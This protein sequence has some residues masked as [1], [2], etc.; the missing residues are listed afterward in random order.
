MKKLT[1]LM[2]S[3]ILA[4]VIN[5]SQA[6]E[7]WIRPDGT[8][9]TGDGSAA[10]PYV[11]TNAASFDALMLTI[12]TN[13]IIH[14]M[15]G[16]F[17]TDGSICSAGWPSLKSGQKLVGAGIDVTTIKLSDGVP[18][19]SRSVISSCP[20]SD[21][22]VA[23]LT[24]D[25]NSPGTGTYFGVSL[26][27]TRCAVRRVKVIRASHQVGISS[28]AY[29]IVILGTPTA[30][31]DGNV[32][33]DCEVSQFIGSGLISGI[34][35]SAYDDHYVSGVIRNN[36]V[37][38]PPPANG[39]AINHCNSR[40]LLIHGNYVDGAATG[41]YGDC[42]SYTNVTISHNLFRN[43]HVAGVNIINS[44]TNDSI[45]VLY[46]RVEL[47]NAFGPGAAGVHFVAPAG[48]RY[49]NISVIGNSMRREP[50]MSPGASLQ[51]ITLIGVDGAIVQNN[52]AEASMVSLNSGNT[53]VHGFSNRDFSGNLLPYM[54]DNP[55]TIRKIADQSITSDDTL[56]DD[57][58]LKFTMAANTKYTIRLKVFFTTG[59]TPDFKYRVAGPSATLVRRQISR[60][61]G[62]L[63]PTTP[64]IADTYPAAD[65]PLDGTGAD[66]FIE[67]EI[68]VHNGGTAGDF[69]FRWSQNASSAT[70]TKVL[71]GS[72]IEYMPF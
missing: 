12:P 2:V 36:R 29:G 25:C 15:A 70:P 21:I 1:L 16:T 18:G 68:I 7:V 43:I 58:A 69:V 65:V 49:K 22:E 20:G 66:G 60:A 30:R 50:W 41:V 48:F 19:D 32:I 27:G 57:S 37:F 8:N 35:M 67:E 72:Y 52:I 33:E 45:A 11:R 38:L 26:N 64:A 61:A 39:L 4:L 53:A 42:G 9:N 47:G 63:A 6:A 40:N 28:E 46:N 71:S 24:L 55:N 23:D 54:N 10:N 31:S 5:V 62:G 14:L 56:N 59:A 13:S 17:R 44:K 34:S 51:S 3:C